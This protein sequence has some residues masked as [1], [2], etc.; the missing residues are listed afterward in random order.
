VSQDI[1]FAKITPISQRFGAGEMEIA[2][3]N[4]IIKIKKRPKSSTPAFLVV[5]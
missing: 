3:E 5:F 1:R 2:D 4:R